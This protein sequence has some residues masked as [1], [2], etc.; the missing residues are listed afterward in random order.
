MTTVALPLRNGVAEIRFDMH[1][2]LQGVTRFCFGAS[3]AL[4]L[5]LELGLMLRPTRLL[6]TL[7]LVFGSAGLIAHTSYLLLHR[8][9]VALPFGS[10]LL[11]AWVLAV[12]YLYGAM[13]H[14]QL[15]WGVF[16]LPIVL[17]LIGL[18][19]AFSTAESDPV[20]RWFAGDSFWG[21]I[22]GG[23]LL[24]A[25]I[26]VC[27]GCIASV[28][29]LAQARR[30]KAKTAPGTGLKLL[31]LERLAE[32][33]RRAITWAFPMLTAGLLVGVILMAQHDGPSLGWTAPRILGTVGLWLAFLLLLS[34]RYFANSSNRRLAVMTI[35]AFAVLLVTLV[36]AH[37]VVTGGSQ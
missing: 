37:P 25:A 8:P 1:P 27:V 34:L 21:A 10:L 24:M 19:E 28:M 7:G 30:V 35:A 6:R 31:S 14:R 26:G 20:K 22:H 4:A 17:I 29:Y 18:T 11:L 2:T 23:L 13:H 32:M 12:F 36:T 16:V 15:A 5:L 3:Y 33:N 9:T